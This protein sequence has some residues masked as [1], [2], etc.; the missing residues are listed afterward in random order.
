VEEKEDETEGR[1]TEGFRELNT[2]F[3]K[4]MCDLWDMSVELDVN[5]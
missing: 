2:E 4:E 5:F 3:E 1:Q